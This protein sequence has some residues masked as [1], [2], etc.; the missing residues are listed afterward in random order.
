MASLDGVEQRALADE[1]HMMDSCSAGACPKP[2]R[3]GGANIYHE[4]GSMV[5]GGDGFS[6]NYMR[7]S[8]RF[9]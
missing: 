2:W 3:I 5:D 7:C 9:C 8:S 1:V 4:D 6:V